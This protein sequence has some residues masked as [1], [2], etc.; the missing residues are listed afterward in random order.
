MPT[1]GVNRSDTVNYIIPKLIAPARMTAQ[2]APVMRQ[3]MTKE[4]LP[5]NMGNVLY[6]PK[7]GTVSASVV[8]ESTD[9]ASPQLIIDSQVTVTPTMLGVQVIITD[10]MARTI[11]EGFVRK[12]GRIMGNAMVKAEELILLALLDGFS[13]SLVGANNVAKWNH[14]YAAATQVRNGQ[15]SGEPAEGPIYAVLHNYQWAA[16]KKDL[17]GSGVGTTPIPTGLTEQIITSHWMGN[18]DGI[19][20]FTSGLLPIDANADAKG[21]V[22]AKSALIYMSTSLDMR[23]ERQRDASWG[24]GAWEINL[25]HEFG[26]GEYF[27]AHGIEIF[28]D[29][30]ALTS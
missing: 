19:N 10:K 4:P 3:L 18:I 6:L 21:A 28:S 1:T 12:A 2:H 25:F 7:L 5:D 27:D 17:A 26:S 29:A 14:I 24:G 16:L 30:T 9:F 23:E 11:Q 8:S 15:S 20:V 22:F 13:T